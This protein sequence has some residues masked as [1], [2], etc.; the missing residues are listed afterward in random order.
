MH[1]QTWLLAAHL[2]LLPWIRVSAAPGVFYLQEQIQEAPETGRFSS[3]L[4]WSGQD[5]FRFVPPLGWR[6]TA[7]AGQQRVV[8]HAPEGNT[9]MCLS[10]RPPRPALAPGA[11]PELLRQDILMQFPGARIVEEFSCYT[12]SHAGRGFELRWSV[13]NAAMAVRLACFSTGHGSLEFFL[14]TSA[15]R[16]EQE[17]AALGALL[18]SFQT[19]SPPVK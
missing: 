18:T 1:K 13:G 12:S 2:L 17:R 16:M 4:L 8:M 15:K 11:D 9:G 5:E 7:E 19:L 10:I 3:Y 14:S 6:V